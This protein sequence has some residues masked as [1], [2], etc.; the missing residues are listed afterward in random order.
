MKPR[1]LIVLLI[2][3]ILT[4]AATRDPDWPVFRG[5]PLH[6]GVAAGKLPDRLEV[7]WKFK[8]KDGI[9]GTAAIAGDT[10]YFGSFDQY[11][12]ALKLSNGELKWKYK[13]GPFKSPPSVHNGAVYVGD[14]D[15][16]FHCVNARTGKKKWTY[17]TESDISSGANFAGDYILFGSYNEHLYCLTPAGKLK[18]KFKVPGGPVMAAPAVIGQRTFVTGCDST[19]HVLNVKT[20]KEIDSLDIG[21]QTGASPAVAG[22]RLYVG[23]MT[24]KFLAIDWKKPKVVWRYKAAKRALEY[25]SSPAVT[26]KLVIVGNRDKLVH[27]LSRKTGKEVWNYP[28]RGKVDSSPVVVGKRVYVGS[29]DGYLY[30]LGVDKGKLIQKIKLG[31]GIVASPA[32]AGNCLV[33]GTQN[34]ILYCLG[35]KK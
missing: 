20:G 3:P 14:E 9:E 8:A 26:D 23:T 35:K 27:A 16:I 32:V 10:V 15:G 7:R 12:Y 25:Y 2:F 11:L 19:M 5:N 33:I 13:A 24:Y 29:L 21:G 1:C 31:R 6:T 28:T 4:G 17:D 18:W 30:V 34:G 22:D